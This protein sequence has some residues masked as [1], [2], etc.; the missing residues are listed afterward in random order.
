MFSFL[1]FCISFLLSTLSWE[2]GAPMVLLGVAISVERDAC[3]PA[4]G[5]DEMV[6][7]DDF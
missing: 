1:S 6:I 4:D 3:A 2:N 7:D 5:A